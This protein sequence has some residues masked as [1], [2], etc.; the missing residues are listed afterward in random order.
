[1]NKP[2]NTS[3][4]GSNINIG[5]S[6]RLAYDDCAYDDK[7]AQSVGPLKYTM[8]TNKIYNCNGCFS[9]F[10][11]NGSKF[12]ISTPVTNQPGQSQ[13]AKIVNIESILTNRNLSNTKCRT[14]EANQIDVRKYKM[15]NP[16]LCNKFINPISS[17]LSDPTVNYRDVAVNRFY[18]LYK[19]P[20]ANIFW[21]FAENS[22]LEA[23]DNFIPDLPRPWNNDLSLPCNHH[24]PRGN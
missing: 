24:Q 21:N 2:Y 4:T 12:G 22:S 11:P 17:R 15:K 16:R 23:K 1:M 8:D 20:Q 10:G 18:D 3:R 19:N 14:K 6:S 5:H 9:N 13:V 7:L